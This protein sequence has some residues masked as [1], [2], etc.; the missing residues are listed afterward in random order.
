MPLVHTQIRSDDVAEVCDW[1]F[2]QGIE[3]HRRQLSR[4]IGEFEA[5]ILSFGSGILWRYREP[6]RMFHAFELPAGVV[7]IFFARPVAPIVWRGMEFSSPVVAVHQGRQAIDGVVPPGCV[8]YG[9]VLPTDSPALHSLFSPED[10]DR[11]TGDQAAGLLSTPTANQLFQRLDHLFTHH[12]SSDEA[13]FTKRLLDLC[14]AA[15]A[16]CPSSETDQQPLPNRQLVADA[17]DTIK[18]HFA[19]LGVVEEISARFGVTRR[20]LERS[21]KSHLGITPYQLLL[22]ERLHAARRLLKS[23][24]ASVLQCCLQAGFEDA[25]RFSNMYARHFGELPSQTRKRS[26]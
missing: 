17:V 14:H 8:L 21:F 3:S 24:Q 10:L 20:T 12:D 22:V 11:L 13:R 16:R 9:L 1:E 26:F 2:S 5:D 15:L 23:G 4:G 6:H 18:D 7:E 19:N 25:S